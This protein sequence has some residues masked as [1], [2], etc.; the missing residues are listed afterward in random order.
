MRQL[1]GEKVVT[2]K[3]MARIEKKAV[4]G[5]ASEQTFMENAGKGI[6]EATCDFVTERHL[7]KKA[8]L[9]VGKGNNGGDAYA[10]GC[11]LLERGFSVLAW[12]LFPLKECS[13]LCQKMH[14][15]FSQKGGKVETHE[16][17][18]G[19][20]GVILDGIL[21][22]GFHGKLET[23]LINAIV[24][25]NNSGLPILAIDIPSGLDG[26]TGN[27]HPIAIRAHTTFSLEIHKAGFFLNEGWDHV[28]KLVLIPFG[29]G[30]QY[31]DAVKAEAHLV[32][33]EKLR[34]LFPPIKRSRHK[35]ETGYVLGFAGSQTMPGAAI[36]ASFATLK[37]GAGIV[38]LF[39]PKDATPMFA[40]AP[41]E[42]IREAWDGKNQKHIKEEMKRAKSAFIGPGM[43]RSVAA[44]KAVKSLLNLLS[45]PI[46]VDADALYFLAESPSWSLPKHT[47]LTPQRMEM[48][49]LCAFEENLL[50]NCQA[51]AEKKKATIVL[52]GGPTF[53]FHPKTVPLIV[54]QGHPAL[55]TAGT[56]DVLTGMIAALLAQ[57][58]SP[59]NAAAVGA[60]LHGIAG[61]IAAEKRTSYCVSASDLFTFLPDAFKRL[62]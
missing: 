39:H 14:E 29:L 32:N 55:A 13:A 8:I 12:H 11:R 37:S 18:F 44:R 7:E 61:E 21:G 49:R 34:T 27:V 4:D 22:T 16:I 62:I 59:R 33:V 20:K 41:Y 1:E 30:Q 53:V 10:A 3:E 25:A 40:Q 60:T 46:V 31:K 28:G 51:L 47:I 9:L 2:V 50:G 43:G 42:I 5:G 6:A 58:F 17:A 24:Q 57:G 45:I 54:V 15:R 38:R 52:K 19:D 35:Y 48:K 36:L 56:G 26:D 23:K